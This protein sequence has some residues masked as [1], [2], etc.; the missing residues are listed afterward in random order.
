MRRGVNWTETTSAADEILRC[1]ENPSICNVY[2]K[3]HD[4]SLS[5]AELL[6]FIKRWSKIA[7]SN[8]AN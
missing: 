1:H 4:T 2:V 5:I 8:I 7:V 6:L 3:F